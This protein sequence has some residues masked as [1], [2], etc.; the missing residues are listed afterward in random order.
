M[1][2]RAYKW[3]ECEVQILVSSVLC[4]ILEGQKFFYVKVVNKDDY[5]YYFL[6][7]VILAFVILTFHLSV[8]W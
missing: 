8:Y 2:T 7:I 4:R 1:H 6:F 5:G 3:V